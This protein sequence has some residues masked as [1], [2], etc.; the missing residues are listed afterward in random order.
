MLILVFVS[1]LCLELC[2]YVN[3][4]FTFVSTRHLK[5]SINFSLINFSDCFPP[6]SE[7]DIILITSISRTQS[8]FLFRFGCG[9]PA[10][11]LF[12]KHLSC[13]CGLTAQE[14]C[15]S[16]RLALMLLIT[17]RISGKTVTSQGTIIHSRFH[18]HVIINSIS[19]LDLYFLQMKAP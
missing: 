13:G 10:V 18:A 8:E 15:F 14:V 5:F 19:A 7:K 17:T 1:Q 9:W 6:F 16:S 4:P 11:A 3:K 2:I 12:M